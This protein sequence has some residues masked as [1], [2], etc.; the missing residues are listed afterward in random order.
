MFEILCF[1]N[2]SPLARSPSAVYNYTSLMQGSRSLFQTG[3]KLQGQS[4]STGISKTRPF[5]NIWSDKQDNLPNFKSQQ[6]RNMASATTFFDFT[7]KDST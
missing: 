6:K 3:I 2:I 7:P 1:P 5:L 4:A